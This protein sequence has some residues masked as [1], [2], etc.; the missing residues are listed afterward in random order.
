VSERRVF[1]VHYK[2]VVQANVWDITSSPSK[3]IA[4]LHGSSEEE[5]EEMVGA[6]HLVLAR[7]GWSYKNA[8]VGS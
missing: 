3:I 1:Q 8:K 7:R 6:L 2:T 4:E 5:L